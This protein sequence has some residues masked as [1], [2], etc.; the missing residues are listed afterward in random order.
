MKIYM[1]IPIFLLSIQ[2]S[3]SAHHKPIDLVNIY[4]IIDHNYATKLKNELVPV[5]PSNTLQRS[6]YGYSKKHLYKVKLK[7]YL[8][9]IVCQLLYTVKTPYLYPQ[10]EELMW[11]RKK[12]F[13]CHLF[14][15]GSF[16]CPDKFLGYLVFVEKP[17]CGDLAHCIRQAVNE[18]QGKD[19]L[20]RLL[21]ASY[22]V[23]KLIPSHSEYLTDKPEPVEFR[24][25]IIRLVNEFCNE[26]S[27]PHTVQRYK[28]LLEQVFYNA[29]FSY[30]ITIIKNLILL[31]LISNRHLHAY[32]KYSCYGIV[33]IA[34]LTD[35]VKLDLN[36]YVSHLITGFF[37]MAIYGQIL[38][39]DMYYYQKIVSI[40]WMVHASF[41]LGM[42][43]HRYNIVT[44]VMTDYEEHYKK[45][46]LLN[47]KRRRE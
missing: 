39:K 43:Y 6:T 25:K 23:Q 47:E 11:Y 42:L 9:K 34:M 1:L 20:L 18:F 33:C 15:C 21:D 36:V 26:L 29:R 3:F 45:T 12:S 35:I 28:N 27:T 14:N 17:H 22:E 46:A 2:N 44:K 16:G 10:A 30:S 41:F 13:T 38:S 8:H 4:Y 40:Y 31:V 24:D 37:I 19:N 5:F 32:L 7:K